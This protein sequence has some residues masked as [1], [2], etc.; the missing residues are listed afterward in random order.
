MRQPCS[1]IEQVSP[2][3]NTMKRTFIK[4]F[5]VSR[6]VYLQSQRQ[7]EVL[8]NEAG[9]LQPFLYRHTAATSRHN[10]V[11]LLQRTNL[12]MSTQNAHT[13]NSEQTAAL[14]NVLPN[15]HALVQIS[16]KKR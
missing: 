1:F 15:D 10:S 8:V 14:H 7:C 9:L 16:I 5:I 4:P 12:L 3:S 6:S 2:F 13:L 11:L